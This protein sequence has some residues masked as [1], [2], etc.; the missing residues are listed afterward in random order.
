MTNFGKTEAALCLEIH[1]V[2]LGLRNWRA[3]LV[4]DSS[5]AWRFDYAF[6]DQ[7]LAIEIEGG[8]WSSGGGRHNRGRGFQND[9]DKYN[10]AASLG[11][12]VFRFSC[13]DV[14]KGKEIQL[15]KKWLFR[16]VLTSK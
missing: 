3:E 2:E 15:L 4:F 16:R 14:L 9:L 8:I 12:T 11:W 5:R 13:E 7:W 10:T 6:P 1:L